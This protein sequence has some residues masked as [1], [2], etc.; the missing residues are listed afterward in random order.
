MNWL[1]PNTVLTGV[2][3]EHQ[4]YET[5]PLICDSDSHYRHTASEL[6]C[7]IGCLA[8]VR[9]MVIEVVC[10]ESSRRKDHPIYFKDTDI[11]L[12]PKQLTLVTRF[13]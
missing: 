12:W 5:E 2:N 4:S 1:V 3:G 6:N 11:V 9:E 8:V 13:L 7:L 10:A